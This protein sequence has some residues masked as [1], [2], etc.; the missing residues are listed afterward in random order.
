MEATVYALLAGF[1]NFGSAVSSSMGTLAIDLTGIRTPKDAPCNF[2]DLIWL[3]VTSHVILPLLTLPLT[4]VLIPNARMT[5]DLLGDLGT[6][7]VGE[8]EDTGGDRDPGEGLDW[9]GADA[10]CATSARAA[11]SPVAINQD[12]NGGHDGGHGGGSV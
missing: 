12:Y 10:V 11:G 1:Q 5:D 2:D 9:G 4:F 3:V 8:G 6:P 7:A